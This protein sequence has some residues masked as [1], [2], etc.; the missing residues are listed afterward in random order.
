MKTITYIILAASLTSCSPN[1]QQ[2]TVKK[3]R[4]T[5][6]KE[7]LYTYT[8]EKVKLEYQIRA[9]WAPNADRQAELEV[10]KL[11]LQDINRE[12]KCISVD[13]DTD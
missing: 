9:Y 11:R 8:R 6:L 13:T 10:I 5:E 4:E 3:D 12:L 7:Q 1:V 2:E